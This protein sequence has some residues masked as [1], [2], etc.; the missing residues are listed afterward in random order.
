MAILGPSELPLVLKADSNPLKAL[1][2]KE[3]GHPVVLVELME[4]QFECELRRVGDF[5]AEYFPLE[6][7]FA[8]IMTQPL[9]AEYPLPDD[10][11]WIRSISWDPATT[12]IDDIFGAECQFAETEISTVNNGRV[13]IKEIEV[14][15]TIF[16]YDYDGRL[17]E[18]TVL[19]KKHSGYKKC[20]EIT[21]CNN[22]SII[23]SAEHR[24]YTDSGWKKLADINHEDRLYT[25]DGNIKKS[26][27]DIRQSVIKNIESVGLYDTYDIQVSRHQ[28]MI[29]NGI[30]THN[31]FLFCWPGGTNILTSKGS[32]TMEEY[33]EN[34][35]DLKLTTAFG[36][37]KAKMR[38]NKKTQPITVLQTASDY[39]ITTPNHPV[40][41]NDKFIPAD[42]CQLGDKLLNSRDKYVEIIDKGQSKTE[43]TWSVKSSG[44]S[45]YISAINSDFYLVR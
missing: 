5:V 32:M 18:S 43:G 40:Y 9:Q 17:T 27:S 12:R 29:A 22:K 16:S 14:G 2:I 30:V 7:R 3:L 34:R 1:A 26:A 6:E 13:P 15:E 37:R 42:K 21:T 4:P 20:F 39:L 11:Y 19:A 24:F 36:K 44:N 25:S 28:N 8:F 31:S 41:C 10:A 45:C 23:A 33:W 38:W 35:E